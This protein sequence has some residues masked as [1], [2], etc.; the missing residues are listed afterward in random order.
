MSMKYLCSHLHQPW[1]CSIFSVFSSVTPHP[2]WGVLSPEQ[3]GLTTTTNTWLLYL[4]FPQRLDIVG[5]WFSATP[6]LFLLN[7]FLAVCSTS[8]IPV[9]NY[10][11]L[12]LILCLSLLNFILEFF[13]STSAIFPEPVRL[14]TCLP[15]VPPASSTQGDYSTQQSQCG[16]DPVLELKVLSAWT[17]TD[18]QPCHSC[19]WA[20]SPHSIVKVAK[21]TK[22]MK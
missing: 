13:Q 2:S 5:W 12:S 11:C 17:Q 15:I 21:T 18:L 14:Q 9:F 19:R 16:T 4:P 20:Q 22:T 6:D 3:S 1:F 10:S 8:C 7:R